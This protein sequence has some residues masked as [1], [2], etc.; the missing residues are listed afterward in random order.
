MYKFQPSYE[1]WQGNLAVHNLNALNTYICAFILSRM[2]Y[3]IKSK[4]DPVTVPCD[5]I[6]DIYQWFRY[7][8]KY[9][10]Y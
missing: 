1:G 9:Q 4:I 7:V 3:W 6:I 10:I 5:V 2:S 8:S